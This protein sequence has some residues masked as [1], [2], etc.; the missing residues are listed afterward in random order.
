MQI[1]HVRLSF[2]RRERDLI[3]GLTLDNSGVAEILGPLPLKNKQFSVRCSLDDLDELLNSIAADANH[4][5]S[6]KLREELDRLY[7][8]LAVIQEEHDL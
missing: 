7:D 4:A 1:S 8:R 5:K 6:K 3:L 2:S